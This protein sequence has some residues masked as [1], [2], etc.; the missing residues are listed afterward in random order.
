MIWASNLFF[1]LICCNTKLLNQ[2]K[3]LIGKLSNKEGTSKAHHGTFDEDDEK[4]MKHK[5]KWESREPFHVIPMV[6]RYYY[7][8]CIRLMH[9]GAARHWKYYFRELQVQADSGEA[10]E[11]DWHSKLYYYR[12]K[13]PQEAAEFNILLE[14]GLLPGWEDSLPVRYDYLR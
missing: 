13:Y 7:S 8:L 14:G 4:Q 12:S 9:P 1:V 2:V 5:V 6:Y 11:R 10:V 3:T